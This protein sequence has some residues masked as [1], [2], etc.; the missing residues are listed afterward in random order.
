MRIVYCG[1]FRL[2]NYDA[3]APRVLNNAK[4][5]REAGHAVLFISWGGKYR[6]ADLCSDEKYRVD[7]FEYIVTNELDA[8]GGFFKKLKVK[9]QRGKKSLRLLQEMDVKPDMII[10]YNAD[11]WWTK[12]MIKFCEKHEI[13]L[14][15]DITE[16]YDNNELHLPDIIPNFINMKWLQYRVPNKILISSMLNKYY[17]ESNNLVLP[18]LCDPKEKKWSV[19]VENERVKPF[20]GIT[21]IY[22]GNPARKDCVHTVINAVDLL[23]REGKKIRFM[24]LGITREAYLKRYKCLIHSKDLHA[25]IIFLGRV[26]QD[27]IPAYYKKADFMVLLREP[28]RKSNAGFPTKFAESMVAGVPVIC[29]ATSDLKQYVLNG[30]TGFVVKGFLLN[31][32]LECL[33]NQILTLSKNKISNMKNETKKHGGRFS[34]NNG[35]YKK[36]I[37]SFF[38]GLK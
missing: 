37:L 1:C 33:R 18:P 25:N 27:L 17:K 32:I 20:D 13:K 26:S 35:L 3:A 24:I 6:D 34:C 22:A 29:N 31:D 16:W 12:K 11:Y 9:L 23:A 15:N 14:C 8:T 30:K 5:F 19:T 4:L 2:P 28:T 21:L 10:M 36:K 38:E 7:G